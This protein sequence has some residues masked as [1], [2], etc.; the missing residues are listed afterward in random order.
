MAI[1]FQ[2]IC[3]KELPAKQIEEGKRLSLEYAEKFV[4]K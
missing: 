3:L 2:S 4:K 1:E